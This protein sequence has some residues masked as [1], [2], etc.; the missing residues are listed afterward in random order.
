MILEW[1]GE[2][3]IGDLGTYQIK[4]FKEMFVGHWT[5]FKDKE[6]MAYSEPKKTKDEVKEICQKMEDDMTGL[7]IMD[8]DRWEALKKNDPYVR[9]EFS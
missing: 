8:N 9:E 2:T 1:E 5:P 6:Y 3:A 7:T 4:I